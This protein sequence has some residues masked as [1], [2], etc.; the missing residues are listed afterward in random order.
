MSKSVNAFVHR[1]GQSVY[2]LKYC[3]L[4][5]RIQW[6]GRSRCTCPPCLIGKIFRIDFKLCT[7][8]IRCLISYTKMHFD[9]FALSLVVYGCTQ[10]QLSDRPA[11][12]WKIFQQRPLCGLVWASL[13]K[14]QSSQSIVHGLVL[15]RASRSQY[16][17]ML[18]KQPGFGPLKFSLSQREFAKWGS[19]A[20]NLP[21]AM[22]FPRKLLPSNRILFTREFSFINCHFIRTDSIADICWHC[23]K[24]QLI[25]EHQG[26]GQSWLWYWIWV[27]HGERQMHIHY[28]QTMWLRSL[29]KTG[30]LQLAL[31]FAHWMSSSQPA[32]AFQAGWIWMKTMW[33]WVCKVFLHASC[34]L[35]NVLLPIFV[36]V[37]VSE[38][39]MLLL[40]H[41]AFCSIFKLK[42]CWPLFT[43]QTRLHEFSATRYHCTYLQSYRI[44]RAPHAFH[45]LLRLYRTTDHQ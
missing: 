17:E 3:F 43:M 11:K 37:W 16:A 10:S 31:V 12:V 25:S 9:H 24:R 22:L 6:D 41:V 7:I 20:C 14:I 27:L 32:P 8:Q 30:K 33:W 38:L 36:P 1:H 2:C 26:T 28:L 45:H 42:S 18:F 44:Q 29:S 4:Q 34:D 5:R 35:S 21:F 19:S 40:Y 13:T 39:H 15:T 23:N